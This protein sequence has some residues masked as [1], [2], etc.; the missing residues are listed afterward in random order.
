MIRVLRLRLAAPLM[1]FGGPIVD[2]NGVIDRFPGVALLTG[3]LGNALGFDHRD[4]ERL[5]ALQRRLRIAS[6][7]DRAGVLLT[8]FQTVELSGRDRGWTTRGRPEG[9]GGGDATYDGPHLRYRDHWADS[10]VTVA[11]TLAGVEAPSLDELARA[12]DEPERPLFIGRKPCLPAERLLL[13]L[14]ETGSLLEALRSA[15]PHPGCDTDIFP[16]QWPDDGEGENEAGWD[17]RVVWDLRDWR[18][19]LHTGQRLVREGRLSAAGG[20]S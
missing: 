20:G 10:V 15:P 14:T 13:D 16:A 18:N 4:G 12:L 11:L 2:Q 19:N 7:V 8:D 17:L 5:D 3:L 1:A 6:R 9:R